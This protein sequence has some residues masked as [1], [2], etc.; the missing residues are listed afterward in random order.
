MRINSKVLNQVKH[1]DNFNNEINLVD[2]HT[3]KTTISLKYT[4]IVFANGINMYYEMHGKMNMPLVILIGGLSR[5]HTVWNSIIKELSLD[6]Q[7]LVYDNRGTGQTG[8]FEQPVYT[9]ELLADDLAALIDALKIT[10]SAYIVGHSMGGF[11]AQ[12]LAVKYPNKVCGLMLCNTCI[13]QPEAGQRYLKE[14]LQCLDSNMS[15]ENMLRSTVPWIFSKKFLTENKIEDMIEAAKINPYPQSSESLPKQIIA[16][17]THN[18]SE[19]IANIKVPT[20]ILTGDE[21]IVM[22]AQVCREM[23]SQ[24]VNSK[25]VILPGAAHMLQ[26]EQPGVTCEIIKKFVVTNETTRKMLLPL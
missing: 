14:R 17:L 20:T 13:K 23:Q 9:V 15:V 4:G 10:N 11:V 3:S 25:L 19:I 2:K 6:F 12:Y 5:D 7:V 1:T 8:Y 21:D 18:S 26:I 16:C 24:I 22:T